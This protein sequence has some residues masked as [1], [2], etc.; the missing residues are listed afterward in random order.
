[1]SCKNK[2]KEKLQCE[3]GHNRWKTKGDYDYG[4]KSYY[5]CRKCEI[6]RVIKEVK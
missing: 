1:M 3:C 2:T 6:V 5:E 4:K